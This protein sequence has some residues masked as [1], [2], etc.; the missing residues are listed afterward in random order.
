MQRN[1]KDIESNKHDM[2]E[3]EYNDLKEETLDQVLEMFDRVY[4][5]ITP[6]LKLSEFQQSLGRLDKGEIGVIDAPPT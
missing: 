2:D 3:N 4:H 6:F 1:Y 5:C